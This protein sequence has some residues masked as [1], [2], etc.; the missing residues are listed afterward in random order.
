MYLRGSLTREQAVESTLIETRQ[1]AKRQ[2]TWFRRDAQ[3]HWLRGFGDQPEV[4]EQAAAWVR[5]KADAG[6]K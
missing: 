3:I 6:G 4:Q 5:Q 2:W 1:Y